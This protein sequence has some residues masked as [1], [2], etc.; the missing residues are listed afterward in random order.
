MIAEGAS[1]SLAVIMDARSKCEHDNSGGTMASWSDLERELDGWADAGLT[2]TLWWRDDDAAALNPDIERLVALADAHRV[3]LHLA[4]IPR[5]L[6]DE[7]VAALENSAVV[8]VLQHGYAHLDHAPKGAG[9]WELGDH[10]PQSLVLDEL[11]LGFAQLRTAFGVRFLPVLVPPWTRIHASLVARLPE[12]GL[13]ALSME[14]ARATRFAARSVVTLNAHCDPIK[15]KGGARFTGTERALDEI[16]RHIAA[17]RQGQAD[18][19]EPTGLC[20]HHLAHDDET[21][22]FVNALITRTLGHKAV[23][24]IG[25]EAELEHAEAAC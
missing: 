4:V 8:R 3:P 12:V 23:R 24:W 15:W 5:D 21:W 9:S 19:I 22:D 2:A 18:V 20:T 14:G 6:S 1:I 25:I 16:V 17:R 10:R 13:M 11:T 7:L